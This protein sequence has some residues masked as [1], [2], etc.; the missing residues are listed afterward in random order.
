[1]DAPAQAA[2]AA[3]ED[4]A[5]CLHESEARERALEAALAAA[6]LR[7]DGAPRN[8]DVVALSVGGQRF[9]TARATL[10]RVPDTYF[11]ALLSGRFEA[12]MDDTAALFIDRSAAGFALLMME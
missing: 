3:A 1:M 5:R 11:S 6:T 9:V 2:S 4:L 8:D 7:P 12:R 10:T